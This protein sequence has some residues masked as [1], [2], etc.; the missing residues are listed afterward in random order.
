MGVPRSTKGQFEIS[1]SLL[2]LFVIVL[3]IAIGTFLYYRYSI[4]HIHQQGQVL[5]E[6]Q[7]SLLLA[8]ITAM[9]EIGCDRADC[10]DTAKLIPFH[11]LTRSQLK[12]Y[13]NVFGTQRIVI[14]QLYPVTQHFPCDTL[15]YQSI[16]YP[17]NCDSW[18][19]YSNKPQQITATTK[20]SKI[21]SLYFPEL[22]AYRIGKVEIETYT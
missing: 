22:H 18:E 4:Q 1:E 8:R 5:Q 14:Y 17:E 9:P 20:I 7:A 12:D 19:I 15:T 11:S 6:E 2:V 10:V 3:I 16:G 21:V 13:S